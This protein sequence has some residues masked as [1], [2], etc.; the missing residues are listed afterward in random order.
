MKIKQQIGLATIT[1]IL[2]LSSMITI[3]IVSLEGLPLYLSLGAGAAGIL[4][5]FCMMTLIH[6]NVTRVLNRSG[7]YHKILPETRW[8]PQE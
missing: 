8:M 2:L 4:L 7:L 6:R 1:S 3:A 5:C